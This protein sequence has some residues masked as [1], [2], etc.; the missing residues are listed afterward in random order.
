MLKQKIFQGAISTYS[1]LKN[2][3]LTKKPNKKITIG[4]KTEK[5]S[6][7]VDTEIIRRQT[8]L[9]GEKENLPA[10][11][12]NILGRDTILSSPEFKHKR[13]NPR[14]H[15]YVFNNDFNSKNLNLSSSPL[16]DDSLEKSLKKC[17]HN[18]SQFND[19]CLTPLKCTEN[20]DPP[21]NVKKEFD[22][23]GGDLSLD[24]TDGSFALT[25]TNSLSFKLE[26]SFVLPEYPKSTETPVNLYNQF[27]KPENEYIIDNMHFE[28]STINSESLVS[29]SEVDQS[30]ASSQKSTWT[31][32][33]IVY[34]STSDRIT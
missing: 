32:R 8:Y 11:N 16:S 30:S 13:P 17:N 25:S 14:R 20:L 21:F 15:D 24:C 1:N 6:E 12:K 10:M 23:F 9:V 7:P 22:S 19:F 2:S 31:T 33:G 34:F 28:S 5:I 26:E 27:T 4:Y 29:S 3:N 18:N